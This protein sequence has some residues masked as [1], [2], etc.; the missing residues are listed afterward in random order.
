TIVLCDVVLHEVQR[1]RG[2]SQQVI[3]ETISRILGRKIELEEIDEQNKTAAE[4]ITNQFQICHNGDN[5]ILS[6]CQAKDF[7]LVTFDKMLLKAC[8]FVGV[9]A[10]HPLMAGGI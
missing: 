5:K 3:I 10:F 8:S 6:L 2:L 7:V 1:V 9:T 4:Q